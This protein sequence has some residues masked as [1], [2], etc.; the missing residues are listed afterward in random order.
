METGYCFATD[1]DMPL[2]PEGLQT[3]GCYLSF[4]DTVPTALQNG[5]ANLRFCH[6]LFCSTKTG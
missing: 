1:T 5:F 6:C 4:S 2:V 3:G